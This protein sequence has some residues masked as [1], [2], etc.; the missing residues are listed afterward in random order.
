LRS[1]VSS[2]CASSSADESP[3]L[4]ICDQ[5]QQLREAQNRIQ[6]RAQL[7]RKCRE[8]V[9]FHPARVFRQRAGG[10]LAFQQPRLF[11]FRAPTLRHVAQDHQA[12][13]AALPRNN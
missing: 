8:E 10:T 12:R 7:V 3:D 11:I 6:R 9:I 2:P 5:L 13:A 1:I 4:R